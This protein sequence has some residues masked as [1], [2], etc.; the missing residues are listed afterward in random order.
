MINDANS[1]EIDFNLISQMLLFSPVVMVG[2][3]VSH[4]VCS[5]GYQSG[6]FK[7]SVE[8]KILPWRRRCRRSP[9]WRF[10]VAWRFRQSCSWNLCSQKQSSLSEASSCR[11]QNGRRSF[12]PA[13]VRL[14]E[15]NRL[16]SNS[17]G[18]T[19]IF[20]TIR[21]SEFEVLLC[22]FLCTL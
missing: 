11:T 16:M 7:A 22:V 20:E 10:G 17:Q 8:R 21:E 13:S 18:W 12:T 14:F 9:P 2:W 5:M 6:T 19:V 4:F 3:M 15:L 1:V